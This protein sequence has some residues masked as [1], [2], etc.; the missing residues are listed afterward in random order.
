MSAYLSSFL[1]I[2]GFL[3]VCTACSWCGTRSQSVLIV[4][5]SVLQIWLCRTVLETA[6]EEQPGWRYTTVVEWDGVRWSMV[7]SALCWTAVPR[8]SQE[9][10]TCC[11]GTSPTGYAL[12]CLSTQ[13]QHCAYS[14]CTTKL[15]TLI[16]C[17]RSQ[18]PH[19]IHVYSIK[20]VMLPRNIAIWRRSRRYQLW[21]LLGLWQNE[22]LLELSS[23]YE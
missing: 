21:F 14:Y 5:G 10:E 22:I 8:R 9:P 18:R 2:I 13:L 23:H 16:N 11:S 1:T 3:P 6:S 19:S 17:I 12:H 15:P 20:V 4:G 7:A